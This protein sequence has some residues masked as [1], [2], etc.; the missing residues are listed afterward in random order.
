[1]AIAVQWNF[2]TPALAG[3][4]VSATALL[5]GSSKLFTFSAGM[6]MALMQV[7]SVVRRKESV[8]GSPLLHLDLPAARSRRSVTLISIFFPGRGG[9][10]LVGGEDGERDE[11]REQCGETHS[12]ILQE[13]DPGNIIA[14]T[15]IPA[16]P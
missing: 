9:G 3:V 11:E 15:G 7:R 13:F 6:S 8:T 10:G 12:G 2:S 4:M 1:M 16:T 5:S 14:G